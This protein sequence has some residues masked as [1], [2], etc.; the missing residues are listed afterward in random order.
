MMSAYV[1]EPQFVF[2]AYLRQVL[3]EAG[4]TV[5]ATSKEIDGKDIAAHD[6]AAVFVD[7][8]FFDRGGPNALCKIRQATRSAAVIAFSSSDD[9]TYAAS[10]YI[11]GANAVIS[12]RDG[13]ESVVSS[14]RQALAIAPSPN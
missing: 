10:C 11:S 1:I 13:K 12:K 9:P 4:L 14:L 5:V 2:L 8:D 6:P 3:A 7:L